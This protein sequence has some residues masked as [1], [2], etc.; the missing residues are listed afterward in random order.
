M[1]LTKINVLI[2]DDHPLIAEAYKKVLEIVV[3]EQ[4]LS[5]RIDI[6]LECL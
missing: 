2:I 1:G 3:K 6:N 4:I 5:R